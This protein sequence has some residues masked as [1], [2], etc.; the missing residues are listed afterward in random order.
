MLVNTLFGYNETKFTEPRQ[1][2]LGFLL[3]T[4]TFILQVYSY[5]STYISLLSAK[6][7]EMNE[8]SLIHDSEIL[9]SLFFEQFPCPH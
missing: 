4:I 5:H 7:I 6:L 1:Y 3:D 8:G 9:E 2:C